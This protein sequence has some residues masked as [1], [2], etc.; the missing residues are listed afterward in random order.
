MVVEEA[1]VDNDR[2][3][4]EDCSRRPQGGRRRRRAWPLR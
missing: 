3:A 1:Q 2:K 4:K